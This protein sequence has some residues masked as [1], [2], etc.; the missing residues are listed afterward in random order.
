MSDKEQNKT[1]SPKKKTMIGIIIGAFLALAVTAS[2]AIAIQMLPV[3]NYF[4]SAGSKPPAV[5]ESFD[6]TVKSN[7]TIQNDSDY[8]VYVRAKL[9]FTMKDSL[10]NVLGYV[11]QGVEVGDEANHDVS[12]Y[13]YTYELGDNTIMDKANYNTPTEGKWIYNEADGFYYYSSPVAGNISSTDA[14][15]RRTKI[16]MDTIKVNNESKMFNYD[17]NSYKLHV[18]VLSQFVQVAG[19]TDILGDDGK[20]NP[21]E[22]GI[23]PIEDAWGATIQMDKNADGYLCI[24]DLPKEK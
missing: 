6:R 5:V 18:E 4:K 17:E 3:K 8:D 14:A 13:E 19:S 16:L 22:D 9:V 12:S 2:G 15:D 20:Y 1:S 24:K 7:I 21:T 11:P 10:G 23:T